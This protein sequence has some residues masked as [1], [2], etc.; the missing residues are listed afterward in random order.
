[1][2]SIQ[3]ALEQESST[4]HDLIGIVVKIS[5]DAVNSKAQVLIADPS[6]QENAFARVSLQ[7]KDTVNAALAQVSVGDI[8]HFHDFQVIKHNP[9][10]LPLVADFSSSWQEPG[11]GWTCL[12]KHGDQVASCQD[13]TKATTIRELVDWFSSTAFNASIAALPCRRR[14]L[15][16]LH[17]AGISCH[18]IV[19][20]VSVDTV[21]APTDSRKRKRWLP[22]KKYRTT[23][24]VLSDGGEVMPLL[25]CAAHEAAL[26][27]AIQSDD[28]KVL[29]TNLVTCKAEEKSEHDI[30]LRTTDSSCAF[31]MSSSNK[32]QCQMSS[33]TSRETQYLS[34]TQ[35]VPGA[36]ATTLTVSSPLRD[37]YIDELGISLGDGTR[38]VSPN[39][40]VS[41]IIFKNGNSMSYR[42]ATL[43]LDGFVVKADASMMQT[44]CGCIDPESLMTHTRLRT[45][46]TDLMRGLLDEQ[47]TLTWTLE[48]D[49]DTFH[50]TRC[51]LPKL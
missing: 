6:I 29:L 9:V 3:H 13:E 7:G 10:K 40:F 31:P 24:A 37:V 41:T 14:R 36:G 38:F 18:V 26:K 11:G 34:L 47:V 49:N 16:E 19:R 15:S 45:H 12:H 39:G 51:F 30:V 5:V 48:R 2:T 21:V 20:V 46:V 35:D 50:A 43:T 25:D 23:V 17:T 1:M 33:N 22:L 32:L 42:Q 28:N 8:L 27:N 4:V 44:L